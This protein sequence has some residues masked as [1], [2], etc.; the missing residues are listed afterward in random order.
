MKRSLFIFIAVVLI[1]AAGTG[2]LGAKVIDEAGKAEGERL[3]NVTGAVAEQYPEAENLL[4]EAM[5]DQEL[6]YEKEGNAILS[7]YGYDEAGQVSDSYRQLLI[8]F[9][10][11]VYVLAA[12]AV[13]FGCGVHVYTGRRKKKH[14]QMLLAVLED[15]I[16]ENFWFA[17]DDD[18]LR[19][20]VDVQFAESLQ[21]LEQKL[22]LKTAK[23]NEEHD[24]TKTLVTDI[25]HQLKT[26]ISAM[27]VCFDMY[28]E[29]ETKE[30]RDEFL[31][32]SRIQM[33][34]L[35][36]LT[37]ALI[38]ISR[39][40]NNMITLTPEDV[41]L[42]D[43]L[44]GAINTE[45]HKAVAGDVEIETEDF[46]DVELRLDRK[47]TVEAFANIIDNAIKY[48]PP[49][50]VVTIRVNK[51]FSFVRIEI[52]DRGIGIPKDERNRIFARF[53]RGS[54]DAVKEQEGSGVGLYL[55]RKIL[56]DQ[57]GTVSVKSKLGEGST[58]VIQL[59]L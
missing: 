13:V 57:G 55:T 14:Q 45:Y 28:L 22:R 41:S 6:R 53:F 30:E 21:R 35:E 48:S 23:F 59:P 52:E 50:S 16:S 47:W 33:D 51:L 24:N 29:A 49:H 4:I 40:E 27:K 20:A 19:D 39:L 17:D 8:T 1:T 34:K 2:L 11:S 42:T 31:N 18:E 3:A 58:F 15:C 25:S 46:E 32:R 56:E 54:A 9:L 10:A 5:T 36:N 37:A 12:A 7:S 43:V 44:I 26:P 38:N